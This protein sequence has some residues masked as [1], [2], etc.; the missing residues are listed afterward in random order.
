[1]EVTKRRRRT[2]DDLVA[3]QQTVVLLAERLDLMGGDIS[4]Y[5]A[6]PI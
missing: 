1:M 4:G 5:C 6:I 2:C 3:D